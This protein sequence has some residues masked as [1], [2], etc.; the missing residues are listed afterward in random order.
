MRVVC[1]HIPHFCVQVERLKNPHL[2]N[3]SVVIV[4][5]PERKGFIL[6]CSE[7][8][9]GKGVRPA[10][11][12]RDVHPLLPADTTIIIA[13]KREYVTLQDEILSSV[14]GIAIRIEPREQGTFFVDISRLPALYKSEDKLAH[15]LVSL[16]THTFHLQTRAGVG[17]SRFLALEAALWAHGEVLVIP[18]G[19]EKQFL[20]PRAIERFPVKSD[21]LERLHVLG[22]HTMGQVAAFSLGALTSQFGITGKT[23]WETANGIEEQ[24]RISCVFAANDIDEEI[25]CDG[26]VVSREQIKATLLTLLDRLCAAL[27][28]LNKTCR[29]IHLIVDLENKTFLERRFVFHKATS[30]KEEMVRRIMA[31]IE[32]LELGSPIRIMSVRASFLEPYTGRQEDLFRTRHGL[33]KEIGNM[34]SF[35]KT[36]YGAMPVV[37]AI[38]DDKASL[39]PD[40]RFIFVEP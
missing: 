4:A 34:S 39:L 10:M 32:R 9:M 21:V 23:L 24:G 28:D 31:G 5:M 15:A 19:A 8:L 25:V 26:P 29:A 6:D 20:A 17:N 22:I 35:L 7:N 12:L 36:K 2:A 11:F 1:V 13:Q 38:E 3:K 30:C 18:P 14:A 40:E 37:R 27:A 16:I 33:S